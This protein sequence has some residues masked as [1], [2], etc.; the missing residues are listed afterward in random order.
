MGLVAVVVLYF[1]FFTMF[2][3]FLTI[4]CISYFS[5]CLFF[6][7]GGI[8]I[9]F[10]TIKQ[11]RGLFFAWLRNLFQHGVTIVFASISLG[12]SFQGVSAAIKRLGMLDA[13]NIFTFDYFSLIAWCLITLALI[14]KSPDFAAGLTSTMAGSTA[15]IA[16]A[17]STAGGA[18]AAALAGASGAGAAGA[19]R[20]AIGAGSWLYNNRGNYK[21]GLADLGT[22]ATQMLKNKLNIKD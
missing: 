6:L 15:G 17:M 22:S 14:L 11:T 9:L 12:L 1:V 16:G 7:V 20:G 18:G 4:Y 8:F 5:M 10:G 3:A 13:A 19:A 2:F 21:G